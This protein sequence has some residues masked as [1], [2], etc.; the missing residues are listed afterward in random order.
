MVAHTCKSQLLGSRERPV[1]KCRTLSE[2]QTKSKGTGWAYDS[3]DSVPHIQEI[4]S[5][6]P[7]IATTKSS[8][9]PENIC[10][11]YFCNIENWKVYL[12]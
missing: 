4:L 12:L 2:K 5:S 11:K 7:T 6:I 10:S 9:L 3:S 8:K 1:Q